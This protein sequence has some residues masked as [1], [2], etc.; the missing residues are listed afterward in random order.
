MT[1]GLSKSYT[2][3]A[4]E[5]ANSTS[6]NT[7]ITSLFNTFI[8]MEADPPTASI[9]N[10]SVDALGKL[11]LD[12][13]NNTYIQ[14]SAADKISFV[15]GGTESFRI[16]NDDI[17]IAAT[18]RLYLDGVAISGNTYITESAADKMTFVTGGTEVL[19][20][21]DDDI[22]IPA[23]GQIFLDGVDQAGNTFITEASADQIGFITGGSTRFTIDA[24]YA[25]AAQGIRIG[26]SD[27]DHVIDDATQGA[28]TAT[29]YIGTNTIDVTAPSSKKAKKDIVNTKYGTADIAQLEIKDFKYDQ[30]IIADGD[31]EHTGLIADDVALVYPEAIIDR[32]DGLKAVQYS[33]LV[34]LLIKTVQELNTRITA[35]GG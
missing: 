12:G 22:A 28:S 27:T 30:A 34:P 18:G 23:T 32:T 1:L 29:L 6:Y 24:S 15:A 16:V 7:D 21:Q 35:L 3:A 31:V 5:I 19:R 26:T 9:G 17:G 33:K 4:G 8:N 14:E 10:L 11:Y 2:P 20:I 25:Y 13:G